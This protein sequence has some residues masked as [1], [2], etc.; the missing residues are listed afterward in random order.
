MATLRGRPVQVILELDQ[1]P[2]A[3]GSSIGGAIEDE[4][5]LAVLILEG[6]VWGWR[7]EQEY[8]T[9]GHGYTVKSGVRNGVSVRNA[10]VSWGELFLGPVVAEEVCPFVGDAAGGDVES[11]VHF[12]RLVVGLLGGGD[13]GGC[14]VLSEVFLGFGGFLGF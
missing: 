6:T 8:E 3:A 14:V 12:A 1:L 13:L 2:S 7:S 5:D 11:V 9:G 4:G 10:C